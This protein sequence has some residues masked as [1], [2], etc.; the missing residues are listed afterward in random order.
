MKKVVDTDGNEYENEEVFL[1]S[2]LM[3]LMSLEII[4]RSLRKWLGMS[5]EGNCAGGMKKWIASWKGAA[6]QNPSMRGLSISFTVN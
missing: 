2:S 4:S 5:G 3:S 1:G 6:S